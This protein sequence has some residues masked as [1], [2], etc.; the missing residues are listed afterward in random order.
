[1][2][3]YARGG[4]PNVLHETLKILAL[5]HKITC[6]T[7]LWPGESRT[8]EVN[9]IKYIQKGIGK[10]KYVNRLSFSINRTFSKPDYNPDLILLPWDRY[11]PVMIKTKQC[12]VILNLHLDYFN[13]PSKL[14][15][16]EPLVRSML[17]KTLKDSHYLMAVSQGAIKNAKQYTRS[18]RFFSIINPGISKEIFAYSKG[19]VR[20]DYLLFLGRLDIRHKGIDTLLEAYK[21]SSVRVPLKIVGEGSDK[22]RLYQLVKK[23]NLKDRVEIV[24][25]VEGE[26]KFAILRQCLAV[27]MPSR[28][29]GFSTVALEAAAMGKAVIGTRVDGLDEVVVHGKTGLLAQRESVEDY[30]KI[31]EILVQDKDLRSYLGQEARKRVERYT[32]ENVAEKMEHFF[33]RVVK[34]FNRY[35]K[36]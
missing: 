8:L 29:E 34:D 2:N 10:S 31:I 17:I 16:I 24:G 18:L 3:P 9:G 1:M 12:P 23:L 14:K 28:L 26:A 13:A 33:S 6:Y 25:W 5:Q 7:G 35:K 30:S 19:Q 4:L 15:I 20:E 32:Y 11:A 21:R 36:Y 22:N 27:C